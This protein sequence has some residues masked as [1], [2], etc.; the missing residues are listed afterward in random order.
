MVFAFDFHSA[1]VGSPSLK[2]S[3]SQPGLEI[4]FDS[5]LRTTHRNPI[6]MDL[7][8]S[9]ILILWHA[10][11]VRPN[12][13]CRMHLFRW[14]TRHTR[15]SG[16][17][18]QSEPEVLQHW[19]WQQSQCDWNGSRALVSNL[20]IFWGLRNACHA[21]QDIWIPLIGGSVDKMKM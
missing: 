20:L 19:Q 11:F 17:L 13:E 18:Q 5:H 10:T 21:C 8:S 15:Q 3:V 12:A 14:R 7:R 1:F 4:Y 6:S 9:K 2:R 16:K